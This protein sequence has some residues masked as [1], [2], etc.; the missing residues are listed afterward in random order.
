MGV[1]PLAN[2]RHDPSAGPQSDAV[3][4]SVPPEESATTGRVSVFSGGRYGVHAPDPPYPGRLS[5]PCGLVQYHHAAINNAPPTSARR[6]SIPANRIKKNMPSTTSTLVT[7]RSCV[8][9]GW[10]DK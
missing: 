3:K 2:G 8:D 7:I 4:V 6:L 9:R 10:L 1:G 5:P